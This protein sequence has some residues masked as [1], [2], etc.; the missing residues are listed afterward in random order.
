MRGVSLLSM[1]PSMYLNYSIYIIF[2]AFEM[3]FLDE[4]FIQVK[5]GEP[6]RV[7]H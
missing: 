2:G 5:L 3:R 6:A 4:T 7:N 1:I